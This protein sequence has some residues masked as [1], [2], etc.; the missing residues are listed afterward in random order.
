MTQ[1]FIKLENITKKFP[2][3][4]ALNNVSLD[5]FQGEIHGL[6]GENGAGKSTFIKI[7]TGVHTPEKGKLILKG[8]PIK[9]ENTKHA[10]DLE[11]GCI[12]QELNNIPQLSVTDNIFLGCQLKKRSGLLD[13]ETMHKKAREL[14]KDLGQDIDPTLPIEKLGMGHQQMVEIVKAITKDIKLLIMDE[15]TSSLSETEVNE[16]VKA[17]RKLKSRGVGILFVSHKLEEIFEL[18]DKVTVFRD[19]QHV[20]TGPVTDFTN[21]LLIHNMVGREITQQFPKIEFKKGEEI[22][23]VENFTRY[24]VY[25]KINFSLSRGEILGFSGLVGA[26]RTELIRGIFGADPIDEGKLYLNGK[27]ENIYSP[28]VAVRN[29]FALLTEDRKTQGLVLGASILSNLIITCLW[30]FK[31]GLFLDDSKIGKAVDHNIKSLQIKTPGPDTLAEQLSGGNQQKVVVG[32]WL[33]SDAE[34][35]IFDEPTRGI[36]VGAK[37]EVYNLMNKILEQGK[38]IIMISSEL[39]EILGMSDRVLVMRN[40]SITAEIKRGNKQF[41]QEDIMHASW[42]DSAI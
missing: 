18:C 3:V 1:P 39:T 42:D 2:G 20:I 11:I 17:V 38:A 41:N 5:L 9:I 8:N 30:K 37:V 25:Q 33:N 13:Y 32:K 28:E 26:G 21:D 16:L 19:G 14:L 6:I 12:Y 22:L 36:D 4:V 23:R 24:G 10:I 29:R 27:E 15:P 31:K 40:G 7:L 35:Y 34:I